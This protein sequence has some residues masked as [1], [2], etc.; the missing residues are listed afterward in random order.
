[1]KKLGEILE[2]ASKATN[3]QFDDVYELL[4]KYYN[5]SYGIQKIITKLK[6]FQRQ[7]SGEQASFAYEAELVI[8]AIENLR[9]LIN[10]LFAIMGSEDKK[11]PLTRL[12]WRKLITSEEKHKFEHELSPET[13]TNVLR[14]RKVVNYDILQQTG[15]Q[16]KLI[17]ESL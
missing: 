5:T 14:K 12:V 4:D 6:A 8:R 16:L 7:Y 13:I 1:M 2:D 9:T 10:E 3:Y 17:M 11:L 15:Q